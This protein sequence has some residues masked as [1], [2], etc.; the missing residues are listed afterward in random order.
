MSGINVQL[1]GS[2]D[3]DSVKVTTYS[4][5]VR[6]GTALAYFRFI[7]RKILGDGSEESGVLWPVRG[8]VGLVVGLLDPGAHP[9]LALNL[10]DRF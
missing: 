7:L 9:M 4:V 5:A 6:Q 1:Q 10:Y 3:A 2:S 8:L